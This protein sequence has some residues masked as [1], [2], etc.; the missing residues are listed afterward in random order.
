MFGMESPE[1]STRL[2]VLD[3]FSPMSGSFPKQPLHIVSLK[4]HGDLRVVRLL[5]WLLASTRV[6]IPKG[7]GGSYKACYGLAFHV[8]SALSYWLKINHRAS[9]DSRGIDCIRA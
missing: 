1:G 7:A 9:P 6:S 2:D 4:Q 8:T 5:T 3:G